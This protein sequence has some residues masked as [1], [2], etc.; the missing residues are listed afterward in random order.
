MD[1]FVST[2]PMYLAGAGITLLLTVAGSALAFVLAM[3]IGILGTLRNPVARGIATFY[4]EVFRG[5]A[6]LVVM[7]WLAF[8]IPQITPYQLDI[9]FAAILALGLN[10][11]AYGAE[12]VRASINAVPR[13]QT[14]A[15]VALNMSWARRTWRVILPQAWAQMLPTFGNLVIELMKASAIVSL[16]GVAD[17]TQIANQQRA[18]TGDTVMAFT[19]ALVMYFVLAQ[20]LVL[21]VR[22]LERRANRRLGRAPAGGG[23]LGLLRPPS[24]STGAKVT[25][26]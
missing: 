4:T 3:A 6:A 26:L 12:V 24:P 22:L 17:L 8:A 19:S 9:N 7:F 14:E 23:L 18:A 20:L 13:A 15:T 16:V 2:F 5:V 11:G 21:G 25:A 1:F 10:V